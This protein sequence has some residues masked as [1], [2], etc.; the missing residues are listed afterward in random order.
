MKNVFI[1]LLALAVIFSACQKKINNLILKNEFVAFTFE[2]GT[3]SLNG[4]TDQKTQ[5]E[6]FFLQST[7]EGL[8]QISFSKQG[9]IINATNKLS[10]EAKGV[11]KKNKKGQTLTITWD[12]LTLP[13]L[14]NVKVEVVVNLP[15]QSGIADWHLNVINDS[16]E[17]GLSEV[18]FP[19][20]SGF[21][22]STN[23]DIFGTLGHRDGRS[24]TWGS[25]YK[26]YNERLNL[27]YP[28]GWGAMS[29]QFL[30]ANSGT[31][32]VYMATHDPQ[33]WKKD[34]IIEP[35]NEF[36]INVY[37]ENMG[38]PGSDFT[39]PFPF[40][41]GVFQGD[42]LTAAKLYRKFALTAP[43]TVKGKVSE[44]TSTPQS[45][46]DAALWMRG[47]E[48]PV[49]EPEDYQKKLA[50]WKN[51]LEFFGVPLGFHWYNWNIYPF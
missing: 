11:I 33:A 14:K 3:Y 23:Y 45:F 49:S 13:E 19:K 26:G 39:D 20:I 27:R 35:G 30:G 29:M 40:M 4:L 32:G 16:K 31:N 37:A 43:W 8:W 46:K 15:N 10:Q 21:L 6:H 9:Q 51:A 48:Y 17:W 50:E 7:S 22:D 24:E 44:A 28:D 12:D 47:W 38:V 1:L 25:L 36:F 18:S 34:F 42:W 41:F 2:E 5:K